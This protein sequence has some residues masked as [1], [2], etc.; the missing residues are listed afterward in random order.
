MSEK[1]LINLTLGEWFTL[2]DQTLSE[3]SFYGFAMDRRLIWRD[4][5]PIGHLTTSDRRQGKVVL[6]LQNYAGYNC[7]DFCLTFDSIDIAL[8]RVKKILAE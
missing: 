1:T 3:P 4:G 2:G 5:R 7:K 8:L 6:W